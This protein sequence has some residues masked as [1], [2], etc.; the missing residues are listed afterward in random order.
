MLAG[1]C[2]CPTDVG[3]CRVN[4]TAVRDLFNYLNLAPA[5]A[6]NLCMPDVVGV[7]S[8]QGTEV[9]EGSRVDCQR[10]L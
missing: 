10:K 1:L 5:F 8:C 3:E 9:V 6:D 2:P 7:S 4:K